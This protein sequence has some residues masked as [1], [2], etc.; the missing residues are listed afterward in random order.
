MI[1]PSRRVVLRAIWVLYVVEL[2]HV[3][4]SFES[5]VTFSGFCRKPPLISQL[6]GSDTSMNPLL[7]WA[8]W[9]IPKTHKWS[10]LKAMTQVRSQK[11]G[12]APSGNPSDNLESL[13]VNKNKQLKGVSQA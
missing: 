7:M 6:W 9:Q 8:W 11:G 10:P 5:V 12:L 3:F 2:M 4:G 1:K 13:N